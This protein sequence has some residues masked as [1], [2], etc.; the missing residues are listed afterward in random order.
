MIQTLVDGTFQIHSMCKNMNIELPDH[1]VHVHASNVESKRII[2]GMSGVVQSPR[3]CSRRSLVSA[4]VVNKRCIVLVSFSLCVPHI[5]YSYSH[6]PQCLLE[7]VCVCTNVEQFSFALHV[8]LLA[9]EQ[10][11]ATKPEDV[12]AIGNNDIS[13]LDFQ[14]DQIRIFCFIC[15]HQFSCFNLIGPILQLMPDGTAA[16]KN[17]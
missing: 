3:Y 16:L 8:F 7:D 6:P 9:E 15:L 11:A 1:D 17:S 10:P 14:M 2:L 13:L 4:S 5:L 12:D